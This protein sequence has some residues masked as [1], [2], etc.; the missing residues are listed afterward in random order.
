MTEN[1]TV[2]CNV[3]AMARQIIQP[4]NHLSDTPVF[5]T[6]LK[7]KTIITTTAINNDPIKN[8]AEL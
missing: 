3:M 8:V 4:Q 2:N 5:F 7:Y 1:T 6:F